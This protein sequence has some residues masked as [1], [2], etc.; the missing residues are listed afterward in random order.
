[1]SESSHSTHTHTHAHAHTPTDNSRRMDATQWRIDT[2][3][4]LYKPTYRP[5]DRLTSVRYV[6]V[7]YNSILSQFVSCGEAQSIT[8]IKHDVIDRLL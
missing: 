7:D 1:M 5:T 2:L 4:Q 8:S 3:D 6:T